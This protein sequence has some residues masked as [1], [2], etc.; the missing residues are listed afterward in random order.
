MACRGS[1]DGLKPTCLAGRPKAMSDNTNNFVNFVYSLVKVFPILLLL[2]GCA[3]SPIRSSLEGP[4]VSPADAL[5]D[6][7][8]RL[9]HD[10]RRD[11]DCSTFVRLCY[12]SD[13]MTAFLEDQPPH[14]GAAQGLF[15]FCTEYWRR[16]AR[17]DEIRPGD[18]VF[19]NMT[20]DANHDGRIDM[21]DRWTHV[22]IA[23]SFSGGKLVYIDSSKG[24]KGPRARRRSFSILPG[25]KNEH[26]ATD[27]ATGRRITHFETF[28]SAFGME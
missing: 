27:P 6:A 21:G 25:G 18:L 8:W 3:G 5:L 17:F 15:R 10:P 28:D 24:R 7:Q 2:S 22:G 13:A 12:R 9:A 1:G 14:R 11:L 23:E 19:F 16:R 4:G 26:V 20:Y